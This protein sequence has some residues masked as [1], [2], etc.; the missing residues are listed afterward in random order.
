MF[1]QESDKIILL[2]RK[3]QIRG[4]KAGTSDMAD[5]RAEPGKL[6]DDSQAP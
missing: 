5:S 4:L 6:Q 1:N 2:L 3:E